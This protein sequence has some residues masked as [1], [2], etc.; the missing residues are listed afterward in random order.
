MG[1]I[2]LYTFEVNNTIYISPTQNF[3]YSLYKTH[4]SIPKI[5]WGTWIPFQGKKCFNRDI[6][7]GECYTWLK[8]DAVN[9]WEC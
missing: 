5:Q 4:V 2:K 8:T 1:N 6:F 9:L 7:Q 3:N